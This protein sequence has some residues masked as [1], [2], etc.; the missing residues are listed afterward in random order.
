MSDVFGETEV[1]FADFI[2]SGR[3]IINLTHDLTCWL[4]LT[5]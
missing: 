4:D 5:R 1:L 3:A 2:L